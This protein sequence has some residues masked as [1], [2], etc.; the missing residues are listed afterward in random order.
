MAR[1]PE[2][3]NLQFLRGSRGGKIRRGYLAHYAFQ[4][5][6]AAANAILPNTPLADGAT[7]TVLEVTQPDVPRILAVKG[8]AAGMN[9][10]VVIH[11]VDA[12][13]WPLVEHVTLNGTTAVQGTLAFAKI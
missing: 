7:T 1:Y 6:A 2:D 11:G 10:E 8:S 5:A 4:V 9:G 12:N 13:G 3:P